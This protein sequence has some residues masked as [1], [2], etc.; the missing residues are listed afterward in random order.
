MT[1]EYLVIVGYLALLITMGAVFRS[2]NSN[3]SDYFRNGCKGTWWLVGASAFMGVF[4]AWTFTGA[5]GAA[6]ESG[7][8]ILIIFFANVV[9]FAIHA[10]FLAPWFRQLRAVTAPEVIKTRFGTTTQQAYA[11]LYAVLRMLQAAVWLWSLAV[12]ISSVFDWTGIA[13]AIG[14]SEVQF[15]I[16]IVGIVVLF[17]SVSGGSWAVMAT[18]VIQS[19]V[20]IPLTV[21]V[22]VLCMREIGWIDGFTGAVDD[23][24]L[25][26]DFAI[27]SDPGTVE[28]DPTKPDFW[29][30]TWLFVFATLIY[31][32]VAFS[33][34]DVAQKYFGVKDGR[35][36]RLAALL[37][38][39]LMVLGMGFWFVPPMVARLLWQDEVMAVDLK[40]PA[41]AAYAIA[42]LKVL[43]GGLIGRMIVSMLSATMSS[44]DTGLN[45][46]AAVF[47]RDIIPFVNKLTGRDEISAKALFLIGQITSCLLGIGIIMI[48]L[49]FAAQ[50]EGEDA[51]DKGV[52][53]VMLDIGAMLALPM[54]TPL[55]L[56]LFIRRVPRWAAIV[57][58]IAGLIPSVIAFKAGE[59]T[60]PQGVIES[61]PESLRWV[62]ERD[63]AY[64]TKVFVNLGFG[65][66]AFVATMPFWRTV[67]D[68]DRTIVD[69]FF[70]TM[71]RKIDFAAEVGESNDHRQLKVIGGFAF[72][73]GT[74]VTLLA[75]LPM[76]EWI[77]RLSIAFVGGFVLLAGLGFS[78]AGR[79]GR[80]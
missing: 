33:T 26:N 4:S 19:L 34:M 39:G 1:I 53:E 66:V 28:S 80:P 18:D 13:S 22:A 42:G 7:W 2:F 60:I 16:V 77:D 63:W 49:Y 21:L 5:A 43:P 54:A 64:H 36:A 55:A 41:E 38:G 48:A 8:S 14:L 71:R 45:K 20:L 44:M 29:K 78:L 51:S 11:W 24:G 3:I 27:V 47:T 68:A 15:V 30:Y 76:H 46:N 67:S 65:I 56:G 50:G 23:A 57:S 6:F 40:K 52:F 32:V 10:A 72:V 25:R 35:E 62:V 61:V 79:R 69:G 73:F 70:E 12:F 58:A 17:Y 75:I 74:A 59:G 37:A 31:K 9:A